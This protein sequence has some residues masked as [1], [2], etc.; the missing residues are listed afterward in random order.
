MPR[1]KPAAAD[2]GIMQV[3]QEEPLRKGPGTPKTGPDELLRY[4]IRLDPPELGALQVLVHMRDGAMTA[5]FQTSSDDATKLL[6]HSL[7][8]LKQVLESQGVSV[9]KLHVQQAPRDQQASNGDDSICRTYIE[10]CAAAAAAAT[11]PR[12]CTP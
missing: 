5:S 11:H 7:G 10:T 1:N 2:P 12:S 9:D 8:Q 3:G 6:S 4:Q